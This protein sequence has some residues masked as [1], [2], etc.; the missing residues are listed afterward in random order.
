MALDEKWRKSS[1]S[2]PTG[3]CVEV[4]QPGV[5]RIQVRDTKDKGTGPV[6]TFTGEEWRAFLA[7][8]ADGEFDPS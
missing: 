5:D 1:R 6:L 2:G 4:S 8:T 7:G 3:G